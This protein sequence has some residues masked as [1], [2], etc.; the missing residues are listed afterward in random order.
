MIRTRFTKCLICLILVFSQACVVHRAPRE[1][2]SLLT[3][4]RVRLSSRAP[5]TVHQ[6]TDSVWTV[7]LGTVTAV[8]GELVRVAGD[9]V[10]LGNVNGIV[11]GPVIVDKVKGIVSGGQSRFRLVPTVKIRLV[12]NQET[13]LTQAG[14]SYL[15]SAALIILPPAIAYGILYALMN[16]SWDWNTARSSP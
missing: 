5:L 9:T 11:T 7:P 14:I 1:D 4:K 12:R 3:G 15:R 16:E 10:V 2:L 13:A 6:Q 8:E